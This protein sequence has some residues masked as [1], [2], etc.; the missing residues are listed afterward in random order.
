MN[1]PVYGT[2]APMPT[3]PTGAAGTVGTNN[4]P[5]GVAVSGTTAYVVN[6]DANTLQVFNVANPA[7][8]VLLGSVGTGSQPISVAVSGTT[9]Y[10]VNHAG[11][12]LQVFNV[13]S[14]ASPVLLGSVGTGSQPISVAVSGTTA[15][16]VNLS[17][18]TLQVFNVAN[19]AAPVLLGSVGTGSNPYSVA[20]SGTTAYVVGL[21]STLQV[22]NVANPAS[23]VLLGTVATN[24]FP[25][26]VAVIC[27]T[28]YVVYY[29]SNTLQ[30][31]NVAAPASPAL[32]GTVATN[33]EPYSVAVSGT[34]AYVVNNGSGTLQVFDVAAPASPALLGTVAT[35]SGPTSVAVSGTTACVTNAGDNTLQAFVFPLPPR[36]LAL[37]PDG[38]LGSLPLPTLSVAGQSLSISGGNTVALPV[39]TLSKTGNTISLTNGGSVTDADNQAL[40]K[41]G[42]T[43]SLTN[44]GSVTDAD[45]QALTKTGSTISLTNGGSVTDADNQALSLSGTTLSLTSGGSVTLPPGADNLGDHNATT[46]LNLG[47]HLLVGNGG[48]TGLAITSAGNVGIGT[49]TPATTLH[50]RTA[51]NS[52][53]ILVG[54]TND[55]AGALYLGNPAHGLL[56]SYS[57]GANDVGL[58]TT[59]GTLYLS[60]AGTSTGQFALLNNGNVGIGVS[61]SQK[62]DVAGTTRTTGLQVTG[63]AAAG[64]VLTADAAGTA[65]WTTP[66]LSLSGQ[67]LSIGGGNTVAI[68][69]TADN[70]GNHTATTN[71]NLGTHQLVG[72]GGT[73]GLAV[74]S[75]GNVG[76]GA[77]APAAN[78]LAVVGAG[79]GI[80]PLLLLRNPTGGTG[81]G[82]GIDLQT[83]DPGSNP[84]SARIAA[85]DDGAN[86]SHLTFLTKAPGAA[87]NPLTERLRIASNGHVGVGTTAPGHPLTVQ[88][89]GGGAALG[90]NTSAG[91]DKYNFS[92]TNG[93][94]NLSES[95]VAGGRLF[96]QE[97]TG[98]VGLG[99][100]APAQKLDV[101]GN[102]AVGGNVGVGGNAT[103]SGN[104]NIGG[105][106]LVA[107]PPASSRT[108]DVNGSGLVR[109]P[110]R[111]GTNLA[112]GS[113][114]VAGVTGVG[115]AIDQQ[116]LAI[117]S[118]GGDL[119]EWQSFA[120]GLT[121]TLT[122]L[123]LQISSPMQPAA[124]SGTLSVYAGEGTGG[125]LLTSQAVTFQPVSNTFQA[126]VLNT[127]VSVVEGQKYTYR[128]T[129]PSQ[130]AAW[131]D[132]NVNNPYADGRAS[133]GSGNWDLLFKTYVNGP[134]LLPSFT[135]LPTGN[136]GIGT[137][138]PTQ[139]LEVIGNTTVT[140]R[141][142]IGT[143]APFYPLDVQSIVTTNQ[144][145]YGYLNGSG[146]AG[147]NAPA[148]PAPIS[149][150]AS[151]RVLASEFNALSDARLKEIVGRS[152]PAADLALLNHLRITD[153]RMRDRV[154]FGE[155]TYK[156]VIAQEV[157]AV[158]PQAV[159]QQTGFLPDVYA[160]ATAVQALAGDSLLVISLPAGLPSAAKPGQR[161][162]L[163]GAHSQ[164]LAVVARP[165]GAGSRTLTVRGAQALAGGAVFVYGLEHA[166]VRAVDYEALSMLNVSATQELARQVAALQAQ[167]T[168]QQAAYQQTT[169]QL[170]SQLDQQ[171]AALQTL[172]EQMA[173]LLGEA[174]PA[175]QARK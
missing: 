50:V 137:T 166:D 154:Q 142:G 59:A 159:T 148:S 4:T 116:Q 56:R 81:N 7:A 83:Y 6:H 101:N 150:R 145:N 91:T 147:F 9:A 69:N 32:L 119:D 52:A 153:Y 27:S 88:A 114:V 58:Y 62:L 167:N 94:L 168:A 133:G 44:G 115:T 170:R 39:Q 35:G 41:T 99:T 57:G 109:G 37:N 80:Q 125:A 11:N 129:T 75:T 25:L 138:A 13:A 143:T 45:N 74:S 144:I 76:I 152:S 2:T 135:V 19:P 113:L 66:S 53:A 146:N 46:R 71:L 42:N 38:S 104:G 155:R 158:F 22:F 174:P 136:V 103:V 10:V 127:P 26:I 70:L 100:T 172:Q 108:L 20:V 102:A 151:G 128:L 169:G 16:V 14:P 134:Q 171:Q 149:I 36:T 89:T 21:S 48:S 23:P 156:K 124:A 92:L 157:E 111:V 93:G 72:N 47:T 5:I 17:N 162:K 110:L 63:G 85:T 8:P 49:T 68:P 28:S 160:T 79:A 64:R 105:Q 15:Y 60:A 43:I 173:R 130:T 175:T 121:G 73:A 78:K 31:F 96:V 24:C 139:K 18:S 120:A 107:A 86:S 87:A 95:N 98:N 77:A 112:A 126:Y 3:F 84:G 117:S 90:F 34:T 33:S 165:A 61:P 55:Q 132:F 123:D 65:T 1:A 29:S 54:N 51:D 163:I 118:G 82:V 97:G 131:I 12:T 122:Q 164:V 140:G 67:N 141:V 40:T 30:E 106:L 161:L